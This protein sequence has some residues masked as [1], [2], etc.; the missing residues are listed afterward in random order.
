MIE[1][2]L[3]LARETAILA[4]KAAGKIAKERFGTTMT[5]DEKG[6]Y[7]DLV[8]EVDH[9]AEN[10]IIH[11]IRRHFP[12]HQIDSEE[13][14]RDDQESDW[15]WLVDP[16]D[17]TNNYAIALPVFSVSISLAY[18]GKL[19]LAVVYEPMV[20]RLFVA[21]HG[22]GTTCN[23]ERIQVTKKTEIRRSTI[24]WIQGH[25]VQNQE[26]A[27]H[28]RNHIDISC[29]RMLRLWAPTLLWCMVAK[30]DMDGIVLYRSAGADLYSGILMVQEAGGVVVDFEGIP[31]AGMLD[32]PYLIACH[33][34]QQESFIQLVKDGLGNEGNV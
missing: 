1:N 7:G 29:K 6:L 10:V 9:L 12:D 31:Y 33:P 22:K 18:Q 13:C 2:I 23:G 28:L 3:Q 32:E 34:E 17:G 16:L 27:V 25:N 5:I 20:D 30:G 11:E 19:V 14:G 24:G 26:P 21:E 4:A 8:T 15:L